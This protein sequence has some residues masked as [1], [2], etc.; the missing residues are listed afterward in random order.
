MRTMP[1]R[2]KNATRQPER[3]P[4]KKKRPRPDFCSDIVE[5]ALRILVRVVA[6]FMRG[7]LFVGVVG[8]VRLVGFV[9]MLV[10]AAVPGFLLV[11]QRLD[12]ARGQSDLPLARI[13]LDDPRP[14]RLARMEQ[15]VELHPAVALDLADMREPFDAV[16]EADEE[17]EV[18]DLCDDADHFVPDV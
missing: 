18:G 17:T 13:D 11:G 12:V 16:G 2:K 9:M 15:L 3:P 6:A 4:R 10:S 14:E 5:S 1:N 7:R 8:F